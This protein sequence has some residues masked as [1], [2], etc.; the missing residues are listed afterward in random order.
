MELRQHRRVDFVG[1]G[2]DAQ[3]DGEVSDVT[4]I[5][6][7]D[8][9]AGIEQSV[10]H[11]AFEGACG[12]NDNECRRRRAQRFDDPFAAIGIVG[13]GEKLFGIGA[14]QVECFLGDVDSDEQWSG[15]WRCGVS[16]VFGPVLQMRASREDGE[17]LRLFGRKNTRPA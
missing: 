11:A 14:G 8:T 2:E 12:F 7:G 4:G 17:L 6:H 9:Q 16:H 10:G 1:L 15:S 5:D 3:T 13:Y